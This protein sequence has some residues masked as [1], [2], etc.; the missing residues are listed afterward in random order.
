MRPK[1]DGVKCYGNHDLSIGYY[2]EEA[3]KKL[4]AFDSNKVYTNINEVIELYNIYLIFTAKSIK[5]ELVQPYQPKVAKLQPIVARFFKGIDDSNFVEAHDAVCFRYYDDFWTL[6]EKY[7]VYD[8]ISDA[9]FSFLLQSPE[10][11]LY[12]ILAHKSIV[13]RYD[14]VLAEN[15]RTSEQT[16]KLIFSKYLEKKDSKAS[17]PCFFPNTLKP[18]EYESILDRYIDSV[19]PNVN[20]LQLLASSQSSGEC[21]ISD[22]LRL[23]AKRKAAEIWKEHLNTGTGFEYGVGV[24]FKP[25]D[26]PVVVETTEPF[27]QQFTYDLNWILENKDYP[28]LLNNFIYL[29]NYTD[30]FFRCTFPVITSQLSSL[31]QVLGVKGKKEYE[32]NDIAFHFSDMKSSGEMHGYFEILAKEGVRIEEVYQWFFTDYLKDEF[33]AEG[34]VFHAP[35]QNQTFLEKCRNLS[36][37]M[38]GILKQYSLFVN[39]GSIDRELFE[40][41]SNPVVFGSLRSMTE[42]KYAYANSDQIRRELHLLFSDQCMLGYLPR[43]EQTYGSFFEA[44]SKQH[45]KTTDYDDYVQGDL[46]WLIKRGSIRTISDGIIQVNMLR[47]FLLQN[48]YR[49]DVLCLSYYKE[50]AIIDELIT[51]GDLRVESTLFSIP[52]Q[53]YLNF[54]LNKS[55]YSNG[56]DLRNKYIHS[57]SSLDE[58]LQKADYIS[59]LKIMA[60][61]IIKINEEFCLKHPEKKEEKT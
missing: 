22:A 2:F 43:T 54:M 39:N 56:R 4:D 13:Q 41:S 7:K 21:P 46:D 37:E 57:T 60:V 18:S 20:Y 26:D 48:L 36:S 19:H 24:C 17:T 25:S 38:D 5:P 52:E 14:A 28:T 8:R 49:N 15:M 61:I 58:K 11:T 40:M 47:V 51:S 35:S 9:T 44:L 29:F 42:R 34:F 1:Y 55:E 6:I 10:T 32:D 16:A 33:G 3:K 12:K 30:L 45:I 59:L 27:L 23:K 50:N 53:Q 31:L